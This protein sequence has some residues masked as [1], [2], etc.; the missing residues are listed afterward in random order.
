MRL[1]LA[2]TVRGCG[3]P[4][5]PRDR[6]YVCGRGH[7]YDIARSGYVNLL[8]PQDRR[9]RHPGDPRA[10]A[11]AR[12]RLLDA[13][14]GHG[15]LDRAATAAARWL[16]HPHDVAVDLGAGVGDGLAAA[17]RGS[18]AGVGIEISTAAAEMAARRFPRLTWVVANADRRLPLLDG[19]AQFILSLHAR[20]NPMEC[21]RVLSP[22]GAL[23]VAVPAEDDLAELRAVV[24]GQATSRVRADAVVE[25]H[26]PWFRL[27]ERTS[28]RERVHLD[29]EALRDL[30][31]VTYRRDRGSRATTAAALASLDVTL[32]SDCLLFA[33]RV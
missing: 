33:L 7:A 3:Q 9:S 13:G 15:V 18:A 23:L 29:G 2:C 27:L 32:A 31:L 19:S 30:L 25:A 16:A 5:A 11:A 20:R 17:T 21:A 14:V 28:V 24:M 6:A 4:L 22:H 10:V 1:P 26:V 8:Q 12:A